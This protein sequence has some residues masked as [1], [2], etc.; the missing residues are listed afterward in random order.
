MAY[1]TTEPEAAER[2]CRRASSHITSHQNTPFLC[3]L[4]KLENR[5]VLDVLLK[6]AKQPL[7]PKSVQKQLVEHPNDLGSDYRRLFLAL[8][9]C[10]YESKNHQLYESVH[11]PVTKHSFGHVIISLHWLYLTQADCLS[12]GCFLKHEDIPLLS[13][14]ATPGPTRAWLG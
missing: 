12:L 1:C 3:G 8:V 7:D 10:I 13:G 2:G 6:V 9:N 14:V 4:T 5:G 11:P